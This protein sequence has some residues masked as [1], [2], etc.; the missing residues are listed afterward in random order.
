MALVLYNTL[1]RRKELFEPLTPGQVKMYVCGVTVYDL[2]HLGH[3]RTYIVWDVV[4]RYLTWRGYAVIYVQNFTDIDDKI[5]RRA[6][7]KNRP[8]QEVVETN[9]KAYE[10]DMAALNIL[11]PDVTPRATEYLPE[12]NSFIEGLVRKEYA[13]P[14]SGDVYYRVRKFPG[15]GKL[16]GKNPDQLRSGAS[17]RVEEQQTAQKEDP[18]DFA[19]W[20]DAKPGEPRFE[21]SFGSGRPGWHIEC[22]A[23]VQK[24]LGDS[25]DIHAGG[26]DLQFPHHENEIAQSEAMTGKPLAKYWMHNGFI[27][28]NSEKMSKSLGNFTTIRELVKN[29]DPMA[30]RLFML[31]THYRAPI[32]FTDT[33]LDAA[34]KGWETIRDALLFGEQEFSRM[35]AESSLSFYRERF[36]EA[37]D[38]DFNTSEA[39]ALLFELA[40]PLA[41]MHHVKVHGGSAETPEALVQE[42]QTLKE[43]AGVL[44]LERRVKTGTS[45]SF[46]PPE[47]TSAVAFTTNIEEQIALRTKAKAEKNFAEADRIRNDLKAQ[48]IVL[49]DRKSADGALETIWHETPPPSAPPLKGEA[50]GESADFS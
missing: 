16:S 47:I 10:E 50:F 46:Q 28:I 27:R 23:M 5:I 20:K 3:G 17:A 15:Y 7:E 24:C 39:L 34:A 6:Q 8:W 33:A 19:L 11:K 25:I 44:G 14:S 1:S 42:W 43:L 48:G 36:Q 2:S 31:Q 37:M 45:K 21:S 35:P 32:D 38:D 29:Y 13:Y 41:K 22:S 49:I 12:I 18:L 9:I 40:K 4:R 26:E 30:V